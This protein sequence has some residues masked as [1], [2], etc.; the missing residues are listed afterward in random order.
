MAFF[1]QIK[2]S[3]RFQAMA[4]FLFEKNALALVGD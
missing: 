4:L 2:K 1:F 3:H